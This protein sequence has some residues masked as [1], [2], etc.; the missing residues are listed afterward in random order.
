[1]DLASLIKAARLKAK[2]SQSQACAAWGV[3]LKT[4][5]NWEQGLRQPS[6]E[7]IVR[8]LPYII[9]ELPPLN[10]KPRRKKKP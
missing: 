8:V 3:P 1:M 9:G 2:L 4:L 6:A 5:Q 10:P 7:H